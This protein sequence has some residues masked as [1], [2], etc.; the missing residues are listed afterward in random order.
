M[1]DKVGDIA[2]I[3]RRHNL[4]QVFRQQLR[5][6]FLILL[7][8]LIGLPHQRRCPH[9]RF[10]IGGIRN[11]FDMA[12]QIRGR[13][14]HLCDLRPVFALHQDSCQ[15]ARDLQNLL[16]V[17]HCAHRPQVFDAWVVLC[18]V[19]LC[20]QEDILPLP[21]RLIQS[22]Y[23]FLTA[24]IEMHGHLRKYTQSTQRDNR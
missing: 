2:R 22:P 16:D 7:K 19:R 15:I 17:G 21:H 5:Y 14:D 3:L 8:E 11:R 13:L 9:A 20:D 6:Q 10:G 1:C 24:H 18:D 23:R 12:A 4:Q